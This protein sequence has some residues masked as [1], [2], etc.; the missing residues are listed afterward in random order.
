MGINLTHDLEVELVQNVG[1]DA[2]IARAARV[3]TG[4]DLLNYDEDVDAKLINYLVKHRHGSPFEHTSMTFRISAPIFVF[5]EFHRHRVGWSYNEISGR[6][7]KL[8]PRFYIYPGNRPLVQE[9]S[10]AH[11]KLINSNE[12]LTLMTNNTLYQ[13]YKNSWD[14][15][16]LLLKD[17]VA[18]EV[19][20]AVL[21]VGVYSEMYATCNARSLMSFLSLRVDSSNAKF[22][23]KPQ[24]EIEQVALGME[25]HFDRLF[26]AT[27]EAFHNNGRVSP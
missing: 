26:P 22:E 16:E 17:G 12:A 10:S 11:P 27:S 20:R 5:R 2:A 15:Y 13:S 23:T 19:A 9:G 14:M 18:N 3:S 1:D 25:K 7:K 8:E 24:W 21:P 6:Y 4:A